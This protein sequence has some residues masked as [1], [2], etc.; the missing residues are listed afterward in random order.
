MEAR[1]R[2]QQADRRG[3]LAAAGKHDLAEQ[4][5]AASETRLRKILD[6]LPVAIAI[7]TLDPT[8][9]LSF[10]NEQFIQTFGYTPEDIATIA[11][12]TACA[13][14]DKH[15]RQAASQIWQEKVSLAQKSHGVVEPMEFRIRCKNGAHRIVVINALIYEDMLLIAHLD[16][17]DTDHANSPAVTD[18]ILDTD[19][20]F[21]SGGDHQLRLRRHRRAGCRPAIPSRHEPS[22]AAAHRAARPPGSGTHA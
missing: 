22:A 20:L 12:W 10:L 11:D 13:Y 5:L 21:I 3:R 2:R 6:H 1:T 14:P 18:Q 4:Q 15:Y 9:S 8:P 16:I 17:T 7:S 19:G